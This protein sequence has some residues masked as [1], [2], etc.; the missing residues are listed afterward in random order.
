MKAHRSTWFVLL[1]SAALWS[2]P[3]QAAFQLLEN[4]E[5]ELGDLNGQNG[6]VANGG[7]VALDPDNPDNQVG[8]WVEGSGDRGSWLP[9]TI[10]NNTTGTLFFRLRVGSDNFDGPVLNW[11]VGMSDIELTGQGGFGDYQAQINQNRDAGNLLPNQVR[12]RNAGAFDTLA[13]LQGGQW[14]NFWMVIDNSANTYRVYMQGGQFPTQTL[15]QNTSGVTDF[16]FRNAAG[17]PDTD[18]IYLFIRMP[19]SHAESLHLDDFWLDPTGVNLTDPSTPPGAFVSGF[20]ANLTSFTYRLSDGTETMVDADSIQ[21]ELNG[22]PVSP[23]I[24]KA[25]PVTTIT[26]TPPT[27]FLPESSHVA[28]LT[29]S[30]TATP[31][32]IQE[33][34]RAFTI[35]YY[36]LIPASYALATPPTTDG[37]VVTRVHQMD[38]ARGPGDGNLVHNAELQIAGGML[39]AQGNPRP[40][41]AENAGPIPIGGTSTGD[42]LWTPYVNWE[43]GGGQINAAAPTGPQPDNFNAGEPAGEPGTAAGDYANYFT[44]GVDPGTLF[45]ADPNNFVVETIAYVQLNAGLHRWGVNSDDGFKLT[46]GPG[47][48]SPFGILL[49]QFS[50]GRGASD[51]IFDFVVEQD[52]YYPIRLLYWEGGGGASCEWFSVD[53]QTGRKILIGDTQ[54]YP[55]AAYRPYRNGQGR[56]YISTLR[57][58]SGYTGANNTGPIFAQITDG[59]TQASNARLL[60]EGVEV[61]TGTKAGNVTTINYSPATPWPFGSTVSGQIVYS[62]SGQAEPITESFSFQVRSFTLAD[63]PAD[64][65]WIEAEDWDYNSGQTVASASTMPYAGGAYTGLAGVLNIDYFDNK[66]NPDTDT[67]INYSYRTDQ[68]PDHANITVHEGA[69]VLA[70]E[71][72]GGFTMT[73]NYRLGWV[74]AF[75]GNYTRT[76]PAG[77]YRGIAALSHGDGVGT[78]MAADLDRVTAGVGTTD[79]TLQRIGTFTGT[80]SGGW[81]QSVLVPLQAASGSDAIFTLPGGP[82]T[83]RV[84]ARNGDFDWFALVPTTEEPPAEDIQIDTIAITPD[85]QLQI[86]WTGGG[87]LQSS[88]TLPATTWTDVTSASPATIDPPAE[89]RSFYRVRQ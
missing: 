34:Q 58:S 38:T 49:G 31:P 28:S 16:V 9:A 50:G 59:R 15:L 60:I 71:R 24:T 73:T 64:T 36:G 45:P 27:F 88:P 66:N 75:W 82:V 10:A 22:E 20:S 17:R 80:G 5:L 78:V 72:P 83:L 11:S 67:G 25:G 62:E 77:N 47:Q 12:S 81:G 46:A 85:G 30:D 86:Q 33:V 43:Q 63:L 53:L 84:T 7:V 42:F 26:Y 35:A 52:G 2:L 76:L 1:L 44:P 51:S 55:T 39:D 54:Y 13:D 21:L 3:S 40:N 65:F 29:F 69:G 61:A 68:R 56:A 23:Q 87:T 70:I 8:A 14:Y 4:F 6:W 48:P 37:F 32:V 57:P 79:Q 89:G 19:G 18:L 74:G 41:I